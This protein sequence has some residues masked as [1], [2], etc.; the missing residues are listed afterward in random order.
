MSEVPAVKFFI[1][2]GLRLDMEQATD[3]YRRGCGS[4]TVI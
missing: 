4:N 3:C 2:I 1:V